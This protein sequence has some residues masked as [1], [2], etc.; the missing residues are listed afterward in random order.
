MSCQTIDIKVAD[1]TA[2]LAK[3]RKA[4]ADKGG[5]FS[6]DEKGGA[7]AV[8]GDIGWPVGKYSITGNYTVAGTT[9]SVINEITADSP[10]V[11][12]CKRVESEMRGW[13][14]ET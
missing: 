1:I 9:L 7:F 2:A 4:V 12:T 8:K 6:G 5:T 11:V 3:A 10:K 14:E 13:F